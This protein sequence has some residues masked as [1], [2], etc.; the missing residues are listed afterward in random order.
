MAVQHSARGPVRS[1]SGRVSFASLVLLLGLVFCG[2]FRDIQRDVRSLGVHAESTIIVHTRDGWKYK[3]AGG[4]YSVT[5]DS[6]MRQVLQGEAKKY[7]GNDAQVTDFS[8]GLPLDQIEK[9]TETETTPWL[10]ITL[11]TLVGVTGV[12]IWIAISFHGLGSQ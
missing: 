5:S 11:G 8:G 1:S 2:C 9:I 7:R 12:L 6:S 3:F 10:Y 4:E